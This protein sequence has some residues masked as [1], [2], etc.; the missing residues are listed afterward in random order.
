MVE[1]CLDELCKRSSSL[2]ELPLNNI[3]QTRAVAFLESKVTP[4]G[5]MNVT[6]LRDWA[7]LG[8]GGINSAGNA[9]LYKVTISVL[10]EEN[11]WI[12]SCRPYAQ[13]RVN[14]AEL[15]SYLSLH[16]LSVTYS[17]NAT[18]LKSAF[19][20]AFW[21]PELGLYRDNLTTTLCPQ[22][23]NSMAIMFN[24]TQTREQAKR[25]SEGLRKNWNELGPIATELPDNI[26]PFISGLEVCIDISFYAI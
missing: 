5:L 9:L 7:R 2:D 20:A 8:G 4:S 26:S 17:A 25:V 24:L 15:A 12:N 21:V 11:A 16:D 6:G 10:S 13:V 3:G 1:N 18:A 22:D 14:S 23:G 19:N